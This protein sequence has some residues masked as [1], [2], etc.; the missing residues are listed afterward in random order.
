[1]VVEAVDCKPGFAGLPAGTAL[2]EIKYHLKQ[3]DMVQ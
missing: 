1:M 3:L 2:P